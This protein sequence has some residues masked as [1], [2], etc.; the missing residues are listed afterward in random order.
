MFHIW[1][2][3]A[4]CMQ[5]SWCPLRFTWSEWSEPKIWKIFARKS[6]E[7]VFTRE[8]YKTSLKS[9]RQLIC[10]EWKIWL[11]KTNS[12][13]R[14]L[15]FL[16]LLELDFDNLISKIIKWNLLYA[17]LLSPV[18]VN[19]GIESQP[20]S[21]GLSEVSHIHSWVFVGRLLRPSQQRL[22][23]RQVLLTNNN[24]RD[25]QQTDNN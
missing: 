2:F 4:D 6:H 1:I 18:S 19:D 16:S 21:P 24:I 8:K 20:I 17:T 10:K 7:S 11:A 14:H 22:L 3:A 25:L 12:W 13:W 23:G 15:H 5:F 9:R